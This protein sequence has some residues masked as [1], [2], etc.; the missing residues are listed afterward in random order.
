MTDKP[1]IGFIGVGLMGHGMGKNLLENGYP[2]TVLAHRRRERIED[3]KQRG[4]R[5][6]ATLPETVDGADI[7]ITCLPSI[8]SIHGVLGG[9]QGVVALARP[10]STVID[11]STSDP[12]FTVKLGET[13]AERGVK[14]LDAPLLRGP[15]QAWD[16]TMQI[17]VG[18][19]KA[20]ADAC[21]PVFEAMADRIVYAGA[22]G[23]AHAYKLLNNAIA[24]CNGAIISE[25]FTVAA[26]R[27]LD[28]ELFYEII[29]KTG[30][31]SMRLSDSGP[32]ILKGDHSTAF[33]VDTALKDL[34]LYTKMAEATGALHIAGDAARDLLRLASGMGHGEDHT[35][36]VTAALAK[37]SGAKLPGSKG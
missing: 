4:A 17:I 16:G 23:S 25:V 6:A 13:A 7:I 27:G 8:E 10:G 34:Q 28:L 2:L 31:S 21:W 5:E 26:Q 15:Q 1:K 24:Q 36:A 30:A 35:T 22:L 9:E 19:E 33:A 18:G 3:L 11:C 14:L 12:D 37:L 29:S 32:R 20:V